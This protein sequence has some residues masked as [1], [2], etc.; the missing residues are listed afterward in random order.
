MKCVIHYSSKASV[1][2][3]FQ[4]VLNNMNMQTLFIIVYII[5]DLKSNYER[6]LNVYYIEERYIFYI[7]EVNERIY[8]IYEHKSKKNVLKIVGMCSGNSNI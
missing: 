2:I 5:L 6:R 8:I 3:F 4:L 1:F 7:R